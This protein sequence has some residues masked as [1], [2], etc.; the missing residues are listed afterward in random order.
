MINKDVFAKKIKTLRQA[1]GLS[2]SQLANRLGISGQAVSKWENQHALPD[3]DLLPDLAAILSV[4]L[5]D[6]V[7]NEDV[8]RPRQVILPKDQG[9]W[10]E[11]MARFLPRRKFFDLH[12]AFEAESMEW[13]LTMEGVDQ[14]GHG[15]KKTLGPQD[16]DQ[17]SKHMASFLSQLISSHDN[18]DL[19]ESL[20][21]CPECEEDLTLTTDRSSF[22]CPQGHTYPI[23]DGVVDFGC[24][25]HHGSTWSHRYK[26]YQAYDQ[27]MTSFSPKSLG[28]EDQ[29]LDGLIQT[30]IKERP[31]VILDAGTGEGMGVHSLLAYIDW[32]CTL[33]LSDMSHRILQYNKTFIESKKHNPFVDMAYVACDLSRLPFKDKVLDGVWSFSGFAN[34]DQALL[35]KAYK[36]AARA[37]KT[38]GSLIMDTY[39]YRNEDQVVLDDWLQCLQAAHPQ[40]HPLKQR[41]MTP[42]GIDQAFKALDLTLVSLTLTKPMMAFCGQDGFPYEDQWLRWSSLGVVQVKK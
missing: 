24:R 14:E 21:H 15:Q 34:V 18:F 37:L 22:T 16:M 4:S 39:V 33:I 40:T 36:E 19:L 23:L 26:T 25:E 31:Q 2:Q 38:G 13:K 9:S 7:S 20:I 32:P 11:G 35:T 29:T 42:Q 12:K 1:C 17:V 3:I 10:L 8:I 28:P 27:V 5:D 41:F 30:L 6:L